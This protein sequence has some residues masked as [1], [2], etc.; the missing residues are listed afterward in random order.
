MNTATATEARSLSEIARDI[1]RDWKA[2]YFGAIPYI[3]AMAR[4][5]SIN[6]MYYADS[7]RSVVLYFLSN[8][9]AWRGPKAREIKAEL[10]KLAGVK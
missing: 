8:A 10:K 7:A 3:D 2:P 6:E 1:Q 5:G 4:L 9:S